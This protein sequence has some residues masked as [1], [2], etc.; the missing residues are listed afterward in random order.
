MKGAFAFIGLAVLAEI[1]DGQFEETANPFLLK[2]FLERFRGR[3]RRRIERRGSAEFLF[4]GGKIERQVRD[5]AAAL[6]AR[7]GFLFVHDK[8]VGAE[9]QVRAQ[10]AFRR[11]EFFEQAPFKELDEK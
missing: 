8:T 9:S 5:I 7:G 6:L 1:F 2:E 4:G 3:N 10:A 11:I